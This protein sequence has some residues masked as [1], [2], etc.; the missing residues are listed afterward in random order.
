MARFDVTVVNQQGAMSSI[1]YDNAANTMTWAT[2]GQPVVPYVDGKTWGTAVAVSESNPGKKS[3]VTTLKI[4]L[5]LSCNYACS[6]CSQR[7]VP[8]E[9]NSGLHDV[10]PFLDTLGN[11]FDT[12]GS[13]G[14]GSGLRIEFWGG[15]P[16]VY[17]KTLQ[18]LASGL[19]RHMPRA[20]FS[21]ITNGSL[22]T[23]E[24]NRWLDVMGFDVGVSHD[25]PGQSQ[26]GPDPLDNPVMRDNI[27]DLYGRLHPQG[28]ISINTMI[29]RANKSRADI[30]K[31]FVDV[32]GDTVSIGEGSF[33]DPY[34]AG[35]MASMLRPSEHFAYRRQA[36]NEL[37]AGIASNFGISS[38][39]VIN[40]IDSLRYR[41][42]ASTVT[43]KCG[44]DRP[45]NMAVTLKG[46]VVTCQNVSP[47]SAAP[48]GQSHKLGNV[49]ELAKVELKTSTHWSHRKDCPDCPVLHLCRGACMFL[50]GEKFSAACDTSYSDNIP[51]FAAAIEFL[52]GCVPV[53]IS[54]PHRHERHD[55]W[56]RSV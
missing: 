52:T 21:I 49:A 43:Q 40:F 12:N 35:G 38:Q 32:F 6:Y 37:R 29:T 4:S 7:F 11:W 50:D 20:K 24:I 23:P 54:G 17:W 15:E 31:F 8:H 33:V 13:D 51:F 28:R 9:T 14:Y 56:G 5:G 53:H 41:K 55:L 1:L 18:P 42:P 36:F 46:D 30:Q 3:D 19:R 26:R 34:D 39:K 2:T 47:V 10:A 27:M 25:G 48:N 16:L 45:D 44:M 22:L